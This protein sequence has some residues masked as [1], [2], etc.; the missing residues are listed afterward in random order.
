VQ[1][2][3]I[4]GGACGL[5]LASVISSKFKVTIFEQ[6]D[7]LGKKILA[8]G[9]GRCNIS[10][11]NVTV[12][13]YFGN[14]KKLV[15]NVLEHFTFNDLE[16]FFNDLGLVLNIKENGKVYP[17]SNEAKSVLNALLMSL[18]NKNIQLCTNTKINS[19]KRQ[20]GSFLVNG[21]VFDKVIIC[22]GSSAYPQLGGNESG[23]SIAKSFGHTIIKPTP[24]L[25]GL[26]LNSP[27]HDKMTGIKANATVS[28]YESENLKQTATGDILFT[29]YGISGFAILDISQY[30][31]L[32]H[33]N[34]ISL[35]FIPD[36]TTEQIEQIIANLKHHSIHQILSNIIPTKIASNVLKSINIKNETI[37]NK[38]SKENIHKI[39]HTIKNFKLEVINT[40]GFKHSEVTNGG[41]NS[42]EINPKT[43]ES[44]LVKNL[45]FGGEILDIT[46]K[47]GGFN[48]HFA[49]GCGSTIAEA[50]VSK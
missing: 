30:V 27:Y 22:N 35:D 10:N 6:N 33:K 45:Y 41:I 18:E 32:N 5:V 44:N 4:G 14:N 17:Y 9:N 1:I 46:G 25:V 31:N 2:A 23:Y 34:F 38:L 15:K 36:I 42:N 50:I 19:I 13:D 28:L 20:N 21:K 37:A 47:R 39:L 48:L 24:S 43:L 26:E 49:F 11:V 3:I 8:S 29:K 12:S 7:S 16:K 40:H